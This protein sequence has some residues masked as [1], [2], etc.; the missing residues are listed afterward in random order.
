MATV[1]TTGGKTGTGTAEGKESEV[2]AVEH[3]GTG[4]IEGL[5]PGEARFRFGGK[6][7]EAGKGTPKPPEARGGAKPDVK[8]QQ[9]GPD[10][11]PIVPPAGGRPDGAGLNALNEKPVN[12]NNLNG[13]NP[14]DLP[15]SKTTGQSAAP[16][17]AGRDQN[18][19]IEHEDLVGHDAEGNR[20][21]IRPVISTGS[22]DRSTE[23]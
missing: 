2:S 3:G 19:Q 11:K 1:G 22:L 17:M 5:V 13:N 4:A 16:G 18:Q 21:L 6:K 14:T 12:P 7:G 15:G 20:I 23:R 10:G 9:L 8:G